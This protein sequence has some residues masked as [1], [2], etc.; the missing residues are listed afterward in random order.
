M[1]AEGYGNIELA[2]STYYELPSMARA[3]ACLGCS[4]C[5]AQCVNGLDIASKM[6]TA[7]RMYA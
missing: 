1:Y 2:R 7:L 5:T 3:S 6:R 4:V